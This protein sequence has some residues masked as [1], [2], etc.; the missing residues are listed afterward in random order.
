M[1]LDC[2][3]LQRGD[4]CLD[5]NNIEWEYIGTAVTGERDKPFVFN[6]THNSGGNLRTN[7][8]GYSSPTR[9]IVGKKPEQ[10]VL[11]GWFNIFDD[12]VYGPY[13]TK[14][15]ADKYYGNNRISCI[16]IMHSYYVGEGL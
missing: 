2:R 7:L 16:H 9:Q 1:T 15:I 13:K 12:A 10:R 8:Q 11:T 3:L 6:V 14:E 5:N 4:I